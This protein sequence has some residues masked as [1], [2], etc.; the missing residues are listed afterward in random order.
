MTKEVI[1]IKQNNSEEIGSFNLIISVREIRD[2]RVNVAIGYPGLPSLKNWLSTGDELL[3]ETP[4]GTFDI[5]VMSQTLFEA[6]F[7]V[8]LLSPMPSIIAGFSSSDPSNTQFSQIELEKIALSIEDVKTKLS[9]QPE[10]QPEQIALINRKLDEINYAATRL[11]RKDWINYAAGA[12]TSTCVSAAFTPN[13]AKSIFSSLN[14]AFAWLFNGA[15]L[16][17]Q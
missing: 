16:L 6:K 3:Y 17:I 10:I 2:N 9:L 14:S 15:T 7:L 13:I 4:Q 1:Q 8:T 12:I 5:R 11:G